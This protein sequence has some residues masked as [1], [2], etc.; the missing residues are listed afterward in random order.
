MVG[1]GTGYEGIADSVLV[2]Q[3]TAHIMETAETGWLQIDTFLH[4][5]YPEITAGVFGEGVDLASGQVDLHAEVGVGGELAVARVEN[6][7]ALAVVADE[8]SAVAVTI[9]C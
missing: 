3:L 5:A 4:H 7:D 2:A 9:E 1:R 6:G 8:Y